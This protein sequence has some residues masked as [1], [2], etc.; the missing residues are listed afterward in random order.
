[1]FACRGTEASKATRVFVALEARK[2]ADE[3]RSKRGRLL[4]VVHVSKDSFHRRAA[5]QNTCAQ[6]VISVYHRLNMRGGRLDLKQ[7]A[8]GRPAEINQV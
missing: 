2:R 4:T 1:M 7:V 5:K 3:K 6:Q 8:R